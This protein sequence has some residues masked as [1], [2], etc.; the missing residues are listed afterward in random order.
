VNYFFRGK[1]FFA[2]SKFFWRKIADFGKSRQ[3]PISGG[4]RAIQRF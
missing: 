3:P 4:W 1:Y 2:D